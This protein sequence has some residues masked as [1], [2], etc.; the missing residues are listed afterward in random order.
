V[1]GKPVTQTRV[2]RQRNQKLVQDV[3]ARYL[4]EHGQLA[5][6]VCGLDFE[7]VYGE[8]GSGYI[9]AHHPEPMAE[10]EYEQTFT[11]L[12]DIALL[13]ANCHRMIHRKNPPY[14]VDELKA[15][16]QQQRTTNL[17]LNATERKLS[18]V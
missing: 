1:E 14:R 16:V 18:N 2:L 6:E 3:K 10:L 9:E 13:C 11:Q 7:Q 12:D 8:I 15:I 17:S 4:A 5:C